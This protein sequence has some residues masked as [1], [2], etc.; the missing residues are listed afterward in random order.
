MRFRIVRNVVKCLACEKQFIL[1]I[2]IGYEPE[3]KFYITRPKCDSGIRGKLI[4][5]P[6]R[7]DGKV[8]SQD[9]SIEDS[10]N[11]KEKN[12]P[13]RNIDVDH[14]VERRILDSDGISPSLHFVS[15]VKDSEFRVFEQ[16]SSQVL[17]YYNKIL[18]IVKRSETLFSNRKL[19]QLE[20]NMLSITS[21]VN[22]PPAYKEPDAMYLYLVGLGPSVIHPKGILDDAK[23]DIMDELKRCSRDKPKLQSLLDYCFKELKF[24]DF[25]NHTIRS[26]ISLMDKLDAIFLGL[27]AISLTKAGQNPDNFVVSRDDFEELGSLYKDIFE[28]CWKAFRYQVFIRNLARRGSEKNCFEGKKRKAKEIM[29]L[30]PYELESLIKESPETKKVY[31]FL[32]R[33]LR[34]LVGHTSTRYDVYSGYLI[35]G[36][37]KKMSLLSFIEILIKS[38]RVLA[39][40]LS[41]CYFMLNLYKSFHRVP[42]SKTIHALPS[43]QALISTLMVSLNRDG[44]M[45]CGD[46]PARQVRINDGDGRLC[47]DCIDIQRKTYG[48]K[49]EEFNVEP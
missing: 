31:S 35:N 1:R 47:N 27:A 19:E 25:I 11:F 36:G 21:S 34:N 46:T 43:H 8:S 4:L 3:V 48:S 26:S 20:K 18:P 32:D 28:V 13:V 29:N 22:F 24:F 17:N 7:N 9:F 42:A 33:D 6:D 10:N 16:Y 14:P 44:C 5:D 38:T 40:T 30:K 12:L 49:I 23:K 39:Y 45:I 41:F 37:K 15:V 2:G